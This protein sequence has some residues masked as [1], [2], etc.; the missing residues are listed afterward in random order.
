MYMNPSS[1]YTLSTKEN[2]SPSA[3]L[4]DILIK[5]ESRETSREMMTF[6]LVDGKDVFHEMLGCL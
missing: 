3:Q 2:G 5:A 1:G 4:L 6:R